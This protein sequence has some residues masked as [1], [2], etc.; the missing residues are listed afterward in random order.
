MHHPPHC[1]L[2]SNSAARKPFLIHSEVQIMQR[3]E[4]IETIA[5]FFPEIEKKISS[6]IMK[7]AGWFIVAKKKPLFFV[8]DSKIFT[9]SFL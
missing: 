6:L 8:N 5:Y 1:Y 4:K 3:I 9:V 2:G 7:V